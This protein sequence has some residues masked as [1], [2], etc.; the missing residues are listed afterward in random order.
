MDEEPFCSKTMVRNLQECVDSFLVSP[1]L[2]SAVSPFFVSHAIHT[3]VHGRA[4]EG[5]SGNQHS[6]Q[7]ALTMPLNSQYR[8]LFHRAPSSL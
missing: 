5:G 4:R 7:M 1:F 2:V 6:V 8:Q 3:P